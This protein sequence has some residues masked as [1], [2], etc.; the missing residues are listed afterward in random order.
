MRALLVF[1]I[2]FAFAFHGLA[3]T[4]IFEPTCSMQQDMASAMADAG[5]DCCNDAE[6]AASTGQLCK[7]GQV[8]PSPSVT[9]VTGL[10]L[11]APA[12]AASAP[13]ATALAFALSTDPSGVW[14]PPSFL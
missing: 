8:F 3:G 6:T 10:A 5:G 2:C 12:P 1:W 9:G 4:R 14:R 11:A 13:H 7:T